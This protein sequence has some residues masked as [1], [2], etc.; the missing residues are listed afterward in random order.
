MDYKQASTSNNSMKITI[1]L[2][3]IP[4][5]LIAY[6]IMKLLGKGDW[7]SFIFIF[8]ALEALYFA[9]WI[10]QSIVASINFKMKKD[11]IIDEIYRTLKENDLPT[12]SEYNIDEEFPESYYQAVLN[13]N[14]LNEKVRMIAQA[15]DT[16]IKTLRNIGNAQALFR[17][18]KAHT[19]GIK[20]YKDTL[21]E[22]GDKDIDALFES[23]KD[24]N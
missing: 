13:D 21:K 7:V 24:E 17:L 8:L 19:A 14:D 12:P 15:S 4:D 6:V 18:L 20:K 11:Q 10:F 22:Q 16:E 1:L 5:S 9:R 23:M 3:L 2:S